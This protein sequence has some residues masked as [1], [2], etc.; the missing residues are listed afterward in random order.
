MYPD[1]ALRENVTHGT[2]EHPI[3][4]MHF[5][6]GKGTPHPDHFFVKRHWHDY[7]EIVHITKGTYLFEINLADHI[8][9]KG[10]IC[11]LNSGE[12]HQITGRETYATHDVILFDPQILS[13]SYEDEWQQNYISPFLNKSLIMYSLLGPNM[14]GYP[15]FLTVLRQL[16][17]AGDR[18]EPGWYVRCK[19]LLLELLELA[20]RYRLMLPAKDVLSAASTR[21]IGRYKKIISYMEEHYQETLSL[22][23]LSELVG[24]NSQ[25]LCR[26]FRE[27]AGISP[28][29]YL[30]SY[31]I[32]RACVL[33]AH[34]MQSVTDIA[35][36]CGFDNISYFIRKFREVKG[37][38]PGEYRKNI[39]K[40]AVSFP[41]AP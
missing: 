6:A 9:K 35:L 2:R 28:V 30:L 10:D 31:R 1:P 25:Y 24:C 27:I 16:I 3:R 20:G 33:L 11:I 40:R 5:M 7:V 41:T 15:E 22:Q 19:L 32:D 8:L 26:F 29:Q 23:Q 14:E 34:S 4:I 38:T 39:Q 13:F 36:I 12:P 37:C 21:K 17:T 18:K